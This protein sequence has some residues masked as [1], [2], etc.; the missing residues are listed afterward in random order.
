MAEHPQTLHEYIGRLDYAYST[1]VHSTTG[2]PPFD[3]VLRRPPQAKMLKP[4]DE[5]YDQIYRKEA[6]ARFKSQIDRIVNEGQV[7]SAMNK[8]RMKQKITVVFFQSSALK[9]AIWYTLTEKTT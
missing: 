1:P 5:M 8:A 4:Y 7:N 6:K 2:H 3:F 9:S